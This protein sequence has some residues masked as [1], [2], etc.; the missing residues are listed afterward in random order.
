[1]LEDHLHDRPPGVRN[2]RQDHRGGRHRVAL[3]ELPLGRLIAADVVLTIATLVGTV[4]LVVPGF[5]VFTLLCLVGP[6]IVSENCRVFDGLRRSAHLV[7]RHFWLVLVLVT[8][9]VTFEE[10]VVHAVDYHQFDHPLVAAFLIAGVLGA[11]VPAVIGLVEVVL[12][13]ELAHRSPD[14]RAGTVQP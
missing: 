4:L 14:D 12:A 3:R 10:D 5:I 8:I 11:L 2:E 6:I 7:R 9:P 13:H 1:M